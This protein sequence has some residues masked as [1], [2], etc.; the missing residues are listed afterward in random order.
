MTEATRN[1]LIDTG[2]RIFADQGLD[3]ARVDVIARDAGVN[4]ALINYHFRGKQGLYEAVL[5]DLFQTVAEE[6][7]TDLDQ[8]TDPAD[9][10][11]AWPDAFW[12]ILNRHPQ[13]ASLFSRELLRGCTSLTDAGSASL[14]STGR[15]F[16]L[17]ARTLA[18]GRRSRAIAQA[19]PFSLNMLMLG[20]LLTA[21]MAN[22]LQE[23]LAE[24]LP[25]EKVAGSGES[26]VRMLKNFIER[27]LL[28]DAAR[29]PSES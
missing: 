8:L 16:D 12:R 19:E 2:R 18:E 9:R 10:L 7:E 11:A 28:G 21:H 24:I 3:G 22:P 6:L 26:V 20:C 25:A 27:G 1:L 13:F 17:L 29:N 14:G 15:S 5:A 23:S 4:K